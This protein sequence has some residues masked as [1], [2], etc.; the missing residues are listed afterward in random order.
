MALAHENGFKNNA[1][2]T[3]WR[4]MLRYLV[5]STPQQVEI[6]TEKEVYALDDNV[7]IVADIRDKRSIRW[8]CARDG[9]SDKTIGPGG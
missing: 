5:S 4:Q 2:E 9:A 1:H 6:G 7:N 8:R 3:F